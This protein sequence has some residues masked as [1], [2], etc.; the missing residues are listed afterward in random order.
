MDKKKE[1]MISY[2][3]LKEMGDK[4][5]EICTEDAKNHLKLAQQTVLDA[6]SKFVL[7]DKDG[8]EKVLKELIEKEKGVEIATMDKLSESVG[9]F[10]V[11][12]YE[13]GFVEGSM[14]NMKGN[15]TTLR[16]LIKEGAINDD[17]GR[18]THYLD[19]VKTQHQALQKKHMQGRPLNIYSF[20]SSKESE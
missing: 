9:N 17:N 5:T 13:I 16:Q 1:T 14:S 4:I 12:A 18:L 11:E 3:N 20:D 10:L 6:F 7:A 15:D 19:V 8:A 2:I